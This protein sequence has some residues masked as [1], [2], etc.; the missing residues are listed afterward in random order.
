MLNNSLKQTKITRIDIIS[1][2]EILVNRIEPIQSI[3][4]VELQL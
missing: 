4:L 1:N 2:S 3:L